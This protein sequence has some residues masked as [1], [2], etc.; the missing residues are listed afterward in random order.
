MGRDT[1]RSAEVPDHHNCR[2]GKWYDSINVAEIKGLPA[3]RDL[4]APHQRVHAAGI[5][6]LAAYENGDLDSALAALGEMNGASAEV[7]NVLEEMAQA[8]NTSLAHLDQPE[9]RAADAAFTAALGGPAAARPVSTGSAA[10]H[11]RFDAC[12]G[13]AA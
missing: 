1:W 13:K 7:L 3:Y 2:L 12:C 11:K 10:P 5:R 6:A 4:V 9:R 8:L